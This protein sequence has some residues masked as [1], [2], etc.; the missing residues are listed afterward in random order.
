[1]TYVRSR[2]W[3]GIFRQAWWTSI[4]V[5]SFGF[6]AFV[7][8]LRIALGRRERRDWAIVAAYVAAVVVET[9]LVAATRSAIGGAVVLAVMGCG[10]A[11]ASV[12][13][14]P[15]GTALSGTAL[16][17]TGRFASPVPLPAA[18]GNKRAVLRA[19]DRME[20]RADARRLASSDPVL[21]RELRIGRPDLDRD[22]DD[23]GLVDVNHA[24]GP[25]LEKHLGLTPAET[26]AVLEA[27]DKVGRFSSTDELSVLTD[28]PPDRVDEVSD[29]MLF[30]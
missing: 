21:A 29:L 25:A 13:F 30:C 23:G 14:R 26:T 10:A 4:P 18:P 17:G 3:P 22:Y 7:P 20:R 6:L 19:R 9:V 24:P 1:M 11:H 2:R 8:F 16:S 28:L 12:A 15:S 27:R 5:W